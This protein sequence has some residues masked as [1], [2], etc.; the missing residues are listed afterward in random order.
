MTVDAFHHFIWL[1]LHPWDDPVNHFRELTNSRL[2]LRLIDSVLNRR[3][4]D[5]APAATASGA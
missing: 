1:S 4:G 3:P 5:P 2:K